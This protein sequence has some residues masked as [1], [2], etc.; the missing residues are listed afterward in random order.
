MKPAKTKSKT[1]FWSKRL[2]KVLVR[3]GNCIIAYYFIIQYLINPVNHCS[4]KCDVIKYIFQ[5][6]Q[7]LNN[8]QKVDEKV[9]IFDSF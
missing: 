3:Q 5:A 9:N 2:W 4:R 6:N 7:I 1:Q 8:K